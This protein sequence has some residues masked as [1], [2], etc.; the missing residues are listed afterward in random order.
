MV[1]MSRFQDSDFNEPS[2]GGPTSATQ[3][4]EAVERLVAQLADLANYA[5]RYLAARIDGAKA[6]ARDLLLALAAGIVGLVVACALVGTACVLL[7][8]GCAQGVGELLGG[9]LWAGN[10][11]VGL[12]LLGTLT[13]GCWGMVRWMRRAA[14]R[15]TQARYERPTREQPKRRD[16]DA[17]GPAA[18]GN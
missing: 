16:R 15:A 6:Q 18:N 14:M 13:G 9:R 3:G 12:G 4:P 10:L 1:S 2:R 7:L 11:L 5:A 8:S 17:T